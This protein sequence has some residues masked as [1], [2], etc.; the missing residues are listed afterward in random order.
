MSNVRFKISSAL[1]TIIGK[2]LITDDFIAMFELVKNSFDAQARRV[3]IKFER[4]GSGAARI[5]IQDDGNGMDEDDLINRWLFVAYSAKRD[6]QD[7]RNK[8]AS[9]RVFAGA[10]GIGRF[11]CDRLGSRLTILTRKKQRAAW[12]ALRVNWN[13]F[14]VDAEEEFQQV[15]AFYRAKSKIPFEAQNGTILVIGGLRS[16]DWSREKLQ[17]LRRSLERLVNPNQENDADNFHIYL[18]CPEQIPEDIQVADAAR[19]QG[20]EVYPWQLVNGPVRNFLFEALGFKTAYI[21]VEVSSGG[22]QMHT[23]LMDRGR[24]VYS[25]VETNPYSEDLEGVRI[26]LFA[27]NQRS[28]NEFTRRMGMRVYQ[29]GSIF[30][31]K[32][33]FR[34]HPFGDP[35]ND[36]FRIDARHMQGF[37]RTYGTR[38]L[39]G[40]VEIN[41]QNPA[42]RET[43]SRD[44]GLIENQA[45]HDLRELLRNVALKRLEAFSLDLAS[46]GVE[47]GELPDEAIMSKA[48]VKRAIF[49]I[50]TNLTKSSDVIKIEYDTDFL[51][52]LENKS[53]ESVTALLSN[54]KRIAAKQNSPEIDKEIR[55]AEKQ[56]KLLAKMKADAEAG[57]ERE[58]QRATEAEKE[59]RAANAKAQVAEE[60]ASRATQ[61]AEMA[62]QRARQIDS[63]N[64]FLKAVLSKDLEHVVSLHHSIGQDAMVIEQYVTNLLDLLKSN[65]RPKPEQM[66]VPLERISYCAKRINAITRFATQANHR[67]T[68]EELTS[69]L[70]E[71]I[72]EYIVNI[73]HN[74]VSKP[75]K[76]TI[77]IIFHQNKGDTFTAT[78]APINISIILDNLISNARKTP[79]K[80]TQIDVRIVECTP[81]HLMISFADDGVGIPKKNMEHLFEV[82]FSTTDGS[83]LGLHHI[84]RIMTEAGG[85]VEVVSS[86]KQGAEFLLTFPPK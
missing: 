73:Y 14:E 12:N 4:L 77:P 25:I 48:E 13:K 55:K 9:G 31:Y 41:G 35:G 36:L 61:N 7:Y 80:V 84:K 58:R 64:V 62:Q 17:R 78:F 18:H 1:K 10:K 22:T 66:S 67:A 79:H 39:T 65:T 42:F 74:H 81:E 33:G 16:H 40:R 49:E 83:G 43:S 27:L 50:I 5:I 68:Q 6:Q 23:C 30:V 21:L 15:P 26:V 2:E 29:Y 59:S 51:N 34:I 54:L 24:R 3:D 19:R 45:F 82:G 85:Q 71:F 70:V 76:G 44:G 47:K 60:K 72:R 32:N 53:A 37:Y 46:F 20:Q 57:E 63:Q 69:D 86:R 52:I 75:V 11:S 38:D 8:I 56:L 28:K